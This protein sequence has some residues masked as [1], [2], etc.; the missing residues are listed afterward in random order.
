ML[1]SASASFNMKRVVRLII[2]VLSAPARPLSAV[3]IITVA[4]FMGRLSSN[5]CKSSSPAASSRTD[6]FWMTDAILSAYGRPATTACWARL[7]RDAAT[8]S[9]ARVIWDMFFADLMRRRMSLVLGMYSFPARIAHWQPALDIYYWK[10]TVFLKSAIA[11]FRTS[12]VS[13]L[14]SL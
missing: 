4:F 10:L 5:G 14:I 2:F 3:I 1:T 11:A 12:A 8:I 6:R 9:I 7:I 13:S